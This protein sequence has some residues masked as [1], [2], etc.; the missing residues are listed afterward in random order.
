MSTTRPDRYSEIR[1]QAIRARVLATRGRLNEAEELAR[2]AVTLAAQTD[3]LN[4]HGDALV[5]FAEVARLTG[6]SGQAISAVGEA[7]TLYERKGNLVS[8]AKARALL[9][10]LRP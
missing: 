7:I 10:E 4:L 2:A 3:F 8:A 6:R 1:R 5:D 9:E